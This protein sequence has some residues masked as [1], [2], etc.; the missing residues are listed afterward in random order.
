MT[1]QYLKDDKIQAVTIKELWWQK[2]GLMF[3][4]TGYGSKIP[5][6]YM[7]KL[8]DGITRRIYCCIFSNVGSIYV[9]IKGVKIY[10]HDWQIEENL[11]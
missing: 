4:A 10:L 11:K 1:I 6:S 7:I 5:T 8:S 2:R 9:L 3:T